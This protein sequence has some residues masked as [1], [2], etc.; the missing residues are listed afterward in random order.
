MGVIP[1]LFVIMLF[2][3]FI[4][5]PI[6]YSV[7]I[8]AIWIIINNDF[9]NLTILPSRMFKGIDSVTLASIP[10]FLLAAE[11][12]SKGSIIKRIIN[13]SSSLI[14]HLKGG[15]AHVNILAS[16]FFSGVQ[17][18]V[19]ADSAAIGG[20]LIP[21]MKEDGYDDDLSVVVTA[22]SSCIGP[23]IPPS[24]LMI[25]YA[26]LTE[27]SVA[28]LF[29]GGAIPGVILGIALMGITHYWVMKR[30]YQPYRQKR[31]SFKEIITSFIQSSPAMIVP[32]FI[33]LGLVFGVVT[34]TESGILACLSAL[35]ISGLIYRELTIVKI[36]D[37]L[38]STLYS[39][40][41]ILLI[42]S[43][44]TVFSEILVRQ[45]FAQKLTG[46][47]LS[48]TNNPTGILF[49]MAVIVFILGM[50]IDTNPLLVMLAAP[51]YK[52][53]TFVGIDPIQLGVVLVMTALIGTISPPVSLLVCINCGI[54]K[55]PVSRT[56]RI[57]WS[58]LL[59]MMLIV[60]LVI[61]FPSIITWLPS[62]S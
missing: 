57:I 35:I 7:G 30:G 9:V 25:I 28:D 43:I 24:V 55:I 27:T 29:I 40:T 18:T 13:F 14:G 11:L 33:V 21:A 19:T 10:F 20:L 61:L 12:L 50:A 44:T 54:A 51:L 41:V 37:A 26:I 6:V 38:K 45:F 23:I 4:G 8:S 34:P 5:V 22:T 59:V 53:G 58:Y 17:G 36:I 46:F 49:L 48:I 32:L 52:V 3:I 47:I 16:I 2:L 1:I 15:L 62:I 39:T 60:F 42:I 31:A 56:Y